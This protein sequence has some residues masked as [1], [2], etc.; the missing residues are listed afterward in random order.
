MSVVDPITTEVIAQSLQNAAVEAGVVLTRSAYSP[1]IKERHDCSTA[2]FDGGGRIIAQANHIPIHLGSMIG[3]IEALTERHPSA[4]MRP[5]DMFAANDPYTGGGSHLP[6]ISVIAPVFFDG[7]I[8]A[9]VANIAHHADVGG[10]VPGSEAAVCESIFQEGLRLPP[11]RLV[12]AGELCHDIANI[13]LLNSRTPDERA[14]DLRA[15]IASNRSA[16]RNIEA[17]Y[18]RHG[19]VIEQALD[20]V[21]TSTEKRFCKAI[22]S[23]PNGV[24]EATEH[25]SGDAP[26]TSAQIRIRLT[27]FDE[28]LHFDLEGTSPA[29]TSARN[30]PRQALLATVYTVAKALLDPH[31]PANEG[32]FRTIDCTAPPGS[33]VNPQPPSPVGARSISCGVLSD[34]VVATLSAARPDIGLAP[35]GPH[36]LLNWAGRDPRNGR[37]FVNYETVAGGLGAF[38][39]RDGLDAVRTLASGSANLPVE[40]LEHAYPLRIERY[41]LR[42]G[43]GGA[44]AFRGGV[45]ITR[46]YRILGDDVTVSLSAER[47]HQ[48]ARGVSGGGDAQPGRFVANPDSD[49]ETEHFSG[50]KE[51]P[52]PRNSTFRVLTP[53][54]AGR[55][56]SPEG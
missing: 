7:K 3:A 4:N 33:L 42:D 17:V 10:M 52:L 45:G 22:R 53:G 11:V 37:Y 25:L 38:A 9:Y 19:D 44:G 18:A 30:I 35:C 54:G 31:V 8:V 26:G 34:A 36:H 5:G 13:V 55:G 43:S 24:Y 15:Q 49:S 20:A 41:E 39:D 1:N 40:A 23:V 29:L 27:V 2:I 48:P 6:D 56:P 28:R 47:Q 46:D 21:L 16:C 14:G 32:Y 12:A 50:A 51:V